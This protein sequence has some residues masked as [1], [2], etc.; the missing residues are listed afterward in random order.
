MTLWSRLRSW[1]HDAIHRSRIENEMDAELRFHVEAYADDLIRKGVPRDEAVRRARIEFGGLERVKEEGREARGLGFM[2]T[3]R[4]DL[5]FGART[6]RKSPGFALVTV[7]T[8]ALGIGANTAIFSVVYGVLLNPL[9][10]KEP[11]RLV[12][13]NETTP[14]VGKVSVSYPNFLDWRAQ[15]SQFA[16]MAAVCGVGFNF[17]G[18]TQPESISGEA[19]SSNFLSLLGVKPL[20]GRDF[21]PAEEKPGAAPV[22]L[23]SYSLWQS[24]L[25]ADPGALG[26]TIVLD[27]RSFTIV[28][29]LPA[30]FRWPDKVDVLEPIGVWAAQDS[31]DAT[32]RGAR[33]DLVVVGRLAP[34]SSFAQAR[35]EM[36][37]IAARLAKEYP[38]ANDQFGVALQPIRDAFVGDVRPAILA[39]FGAVVFVMLIACAN[40]ANLLL[41]RGAGRSRE[42]ALR[43]ALGATR[44]RIIR[45]MLT[46]SFLLALF[47]GAV[48]LCL[49]EAGIRGMT[50]L[51]PSATLSG[52]SI[53]LNAVVVLFAAGIM[54]LAAF[55]FGAIPAV[56]STSPNVQSQLKEGSQGTGT[57]IAQNRL[58]SAFVV[59][60]LALSLVLLAG[61]GLMMKSLHLLL[62][63][64]P[65]F[66]PNR[67]LTME[68]DLR[69]AQ[70]DKDPAIRNFWQQVLDRVSVLPGVQSAAVG[71]VVPL[72]GHHDRADI[73]VEGM[74]L[75]KPGSFP[76]P[77]IH[78]VSA[79]YFRTLGVP[80]IAGRTFTQDDTETALQV[81]MINAKLAREFFP[82]GD[83]VGKR[84]LFGHPSNTSAPKW[85]EIV[86]VVGDTKLY[87]LAN[88]ARLE[89]YVPFSQAPSGHMNLLVKSAVDPSAMTSAVRGVVA[90]VDKDQPIF[91]TSTMN[92]LLHDS[93]STQTFT[94]ILL[95]LFST[96]ALVLAAIGI[97]GVISY[98]VAQRT[99]DIG[100]RMALGASPG[101]I[102]Q[103]I[104]GLGLWLTG[105]G[106]GL[107]LMGAFAVTRVLSSLLYGVQST[108]AVTFSAV[109]L[110]LAVVALAASYLPAR[111]AMR[112]DPMVAL[113][114]E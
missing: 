14:K 12:L 74:P 76:H 92:R 114:Y 56:R 106:L 55:I 96:V 22:V 45:Q 42:V 81:G 16:Q 84:F 23:L 75:P 78:I 51:I 112:V 50:S 68:M 105:A 15:S 32:Q 19:V 46:E 69:T 11:S 97:Y 49:A 90:S 28:G 5:R 65:G 62:S 54:T 4:Q 40:V 59:T 6:F 58:R 95:E 66:Q 26:R 108:D 64:S 13:L 67:V 77:D 86:G 63:V 2:D 72:T 103:N 48:G 87:S 91:A 88:P 83:A 52:A 85:I 37:G 89:V 44:S 33:G 70:Y 24:H 71:T 34:N 29:I 8:L 36:E 107:G 39:L 7:L 61:A 94:L 110:V 93:V 101:N 18:V 109:S 35:S 21:D 30:N 27:G 57:G 60:E 100:I 38:G 102:L 47:G 98:S 20:L 25:G 31:D 111:R 1:S 3:L 113:R 104:L 53:Q 73:T 41:V 82:R 80:L 79:G 43:M 99:R 17:A 10:Y 9:P